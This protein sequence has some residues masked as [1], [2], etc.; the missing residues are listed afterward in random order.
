[1]D[2]FTSVLR[3]RLFR[4]G[5]P[6]PGC[7]PPGRPLAPAARRGSSNVSPAAASTITASITIASTIAETEPPREDTPPRR[8]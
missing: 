7:P 2:R 3:D 5:C 8:P 4:L 1:M 6:P